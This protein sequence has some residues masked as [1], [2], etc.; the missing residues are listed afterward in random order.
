[1]RNVDM[2]LLQLLRQSE[3]MALARQGEN[4]PR[5]APASVIQSLPTRSWTKVRSS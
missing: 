2:G 5:A 1:M 4:A 3:N